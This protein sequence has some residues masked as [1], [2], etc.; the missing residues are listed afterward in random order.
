MLNGVDYNSSELYALGFP[1]PFFSEE[2][3]SATFNP[4]CFN[5]L[6]VT[7]MEV[8]AV[9]FYE[10]VM[11]KFLDG[12]STSSSVAGKFNRPQSG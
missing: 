6:E 11:K 4:N 9:F 8:V 5:L 2:S 12:A 10:S 1:T 3:S 7:T